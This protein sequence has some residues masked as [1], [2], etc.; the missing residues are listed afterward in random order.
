[1]AVASPM[2]RR[3][4]L[5][6]ELRRL[7]DEAGLTQDD[8][9]AQ[10]DWHPTKVMRIET[11]RTAPHPN[12]VRVMLG[13]FGVTNPEQVAALVKLAQDARQRGWWY[14]YRDV[15]LNRYEFFIGLETEA[16]SIRNFELAMVPGLL[17]TED[18]ARALISGGPMELDA[19]EVDRRVEVRTTRQQ[20]LDRDERPQ[21]WVIVD[22]AAI[23]RTVGGPAV[24][25]A[26]LE[27]LVTASGQARTTIQVVPYSAG[28]H[29]GQLGP[30]VILG[31]PEPSEPE[32][33]TMET[34]GGNLYVDKPEEVRLYTTAF[35]HLRAVAL[36]P[37]DTRAMLR[38]AAQ[39]LQ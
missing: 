37:G 21:L 36:S 14:S 31:F 34:V 9:A 17:Q 39:A 8:V 29:P 26:Q 3:R 4:Q 30:F 32:V 19:T 2:V 7:R 24:M 1:M 13:L 12:D 5:M 18:Y 22:E 38:A 11:G 28:A 15:L 35:D 16:S 27:T 10:L 20:A 23:R 25:R 6:T 33:V